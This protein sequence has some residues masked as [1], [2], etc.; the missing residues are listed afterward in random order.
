MTQP[1]HTHLD[2]GIE[3]AVLTLPDRR[4][5][6]TEIRVLA[7]TADEPEDK[8]GVAHLVEQTLDKGTRQFEGRALGD[9]FDEIGASRGSWSGREA[10]A[11]NCMCLPEYFDRSIELHAEFL[12][13]PVFP[14]DSCDVAL[15]LSRQEL[16]ALED[17]PQALVDKRIGR[18]AYGPVLGRHYAGEAETLD[19]ITRQHMLDFWSAN[20]GSG[21]ILMSVAGPL[22]I[23]QVAP[24]VERSF[25]GFGPPEQSHREGFEIEFDATTRHHPKETEQEQISIAFRGVPITDREHATERVLIGVLSGG[26][27][28]RLFTEV[29]ERQGLAYWVGAW[30]EHPRNAGMIFVGASTTPDRCHQTY[31]TL[32]RELDR[33]KDDVTQEEIDRALTG[34]MVRADIRSDVT[35]ARCAE[36]ADDLMHYGRPV[37]WEQKRARLQAVTVEDVKRYCATRGPRLPRSVV[38]LGPRNLDNNTG[39]DCTSG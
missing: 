8:L 1:I 30:H 13:Y 12:R 39:G 5:V 18:Q 3:L 16:L 19:G 38:T 21:R 9:A 27:S 31:D 2:C 35:R 6:A 36:Q 26:M 4:A 20:Y 7:G 34:I 14:E 32:L 28:A 10:T 15:E 24:V 23:D 22:G 25:T 29:R 33:V 11:F 37:P 17:D